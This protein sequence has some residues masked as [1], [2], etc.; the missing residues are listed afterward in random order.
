MM[1]IQLTRHAVKRAHERLSLKKRAI[2]RNA[3]LALARGDSINASPQSD[4]WILGNHP[5][6]TSGCEIR[7]YGNAYYVFEHSKTSISLITV[8][9][10]NCQKGG[11]DEHA[12]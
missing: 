8:I 12:I 3:K 4:P 9:L 10:I 11:D 2:C 1:E 5:S 7:K 6:I